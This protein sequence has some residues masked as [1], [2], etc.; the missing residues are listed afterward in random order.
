MALFRRVHQAANIRGGAGARV[1]P[2]APFGAQRQLLAA[3]DDRR[4]DDHDA[5]DAARPAR[6]RVAPAT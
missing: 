3:V 2:D 6:S 4:S 1:L 5:A